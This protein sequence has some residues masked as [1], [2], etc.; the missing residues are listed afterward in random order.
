MLRQIDKAIRFVAAVLLFLLM[1]LT[2]IDVIGRNFFNRPL[3]GAAELTEL[4]L[5][6][7]VFLMLPLIAIRQSHIVVDLFD[8]VPSRIFKAAQAITGI[9]VGV[10]FFGM[11]AWRLWHLGDSTARYNDLTPTLKLPIAPLV[12]GMAVFAAITAVCILAIGVRHLW[13]PGA[14]RP[15]ERD[16]D[17]ANLASGGTNG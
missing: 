3:N 13:R 16:V 14:R 9:V 11:M 2:F 8:F 5:G 10:F 1:M 12:Y 7:I 15:A 4:S 17:A 6:A